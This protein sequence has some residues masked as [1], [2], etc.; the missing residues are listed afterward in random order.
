MFVQEKH[1]T[2]VQPSCHGCWRGTLQAV[3]GAVATSSRT[4]STAAS[5]CSGRATTPAAERDLGRPTTAHRNGHLRCL[6]GDALGHG[7]TE[8]DVLPADHPRTT[9]RASVRSRAATQLSTGTFAPR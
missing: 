5:S 9:R 8:G 3:R 6:V 4:V 7:P 2:G 1:K